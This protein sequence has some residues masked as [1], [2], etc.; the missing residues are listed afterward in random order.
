MKLEP[1]IYQNSQVTALLFNRKFT[2]LNSWNSLSFNS[3]YVICCFF[4]L[5]FFFCSTWNQKLGFIQ[6]RNMLSHEPTHPGDPMPMWDLVTDQISNCCSRWVESFLSLNCL[7]WERLLSPHNFSQPSPR[8]WTWDDRNQSEY[9]GNRELSYIIVSPS[10][11]QKLQCLK[12]YEMIQSLPD[13]FMVALRTL[14]RAEV[15]I[16]IGN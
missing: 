13:Q 6:L 5:F 8:D 12:Q 3:L 2:S 15:P 7:G 9:H 11:D 10:P 4:F 14:S 16:T 1:H